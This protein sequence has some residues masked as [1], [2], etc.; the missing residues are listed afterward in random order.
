M[1]LSLDEIRAIIQEERKSANDN[2]LC[3]CGEYIK[4]HYCDD[5]TAV[6]VNESEDYDLRLLLAAEQLLAEVERLKRPSLW[7]RFIF[8]LDSLE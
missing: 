8:W 6:R 4:Q 1:N 2:A 3:Y 5:H 7:E